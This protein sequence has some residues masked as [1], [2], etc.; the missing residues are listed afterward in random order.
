MDMPMS[1]R[2]TRFTSQVL[3]DHPEL[4]HATDEQ[5]RR[6]FEKRAISDDV[7]SARAYVPYA[8][9][10]WQTV[11]AAE[12]RYGDLEHWK[13]VQAKVAQRPGLVMQRHT[14][15]GRRILAQLRPFKFGDLDLSDAY[16]LDQY[17]QADDGVFV[18]DWFHDHDVPLAHIHGE[19]LEVGARLQGGYSGGTLSTHEGLA[20]GTGPQGT[21]DRGGVP[22]FTPLYVD[23][24][25]KKPTS[26]WP[27]KPANGSRR[28]PRTPEELEADYADH[29]KRGHGGDDSEPGY[30]VHPI[31]H[32]RHT[33][34]RHDG[35]RVH[36]RHNHP[37]HAKYLYAPGEECRLLDVHP[38]AWPL[39]EAGGPVVYLALEGVLKNDSILSTGAPVFNAGSVTLWEDPGAP[40]EQGDAG[41]RALAENY[42][43]QFGTVVVV[44]DSDWNGNPLVKSQAFQIVERLAGWGIPAAVAAPPAT[45]G[46]ACQHLTRD[47][48]GGVHLP[49]AGHKQGV[50]DWLGSGGGLNEMIVMPKTV[51]KETPKL[52]RRR[53]DQYER[54]T[55]VLDHLRNIVSPDGRAVFTY[56]ALG[57]TVGRNKN[58]VRAAI[59]SLEK[60]RLLTQ[61]DSMPYVDSARAERWPM[62]A[63]R[64]DL[65]LVPERETTTLGEYLD[66]RRS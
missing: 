66:R 24:H 29:I 36:G 9:S 27:I 59:E 58:A 11:L 33:K 51:E 38:N 57:A 26:E 31:P 22:T 63:V 21:V 7:W 35:K 1:K 23:E 61:E 49:D 47:I 14:W 20:D 56:R 52:L 44:P 54:D 55:A 62:T 43:R 17:G 4:A 6:V 30:H 12:P 13:S 32:V 48:G 28:K 34:R 16:L 40:G 53:A 15:G 5:T 18:R 60:E 10:D 39:L 65:G 64:L 8:Q 2:P 3:H 50:D 25:H 42:L 45:C 19:G 37:Q 46:V 41:L